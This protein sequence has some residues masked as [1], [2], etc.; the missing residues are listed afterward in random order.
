MWL[1]SPGFELEFNLG[2]QL[3]DLVSDVPLRCAKP[4][5]GSKGDDVPTELDDAAQVQVRKS[6]VPEQV[7]MTPVVEVADVEELGALDRKGRGFYVFL[8]FREESARLMLCQVLFESLKNK[9][10]VCSNGT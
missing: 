4:L 7:A 9:S 5:R 10:G 2:K 3:R 8:E 6:L 1:S